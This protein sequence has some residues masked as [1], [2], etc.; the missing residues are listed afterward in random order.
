MKTCT[1]HIIIFY[2]FIINM[3]LLIY[4]NGVRN[5]HEIKMMPVGP[6]INTGNLSETIIIIIMMCSMQQ[7]QPHS[8][9][10][11]VPQPSWYGARVLP[12]GW[13]NLELTHFATSRRSV[14]PTCTAMGLIPLHPFFPRE[15]EW[16][17]R[18]NA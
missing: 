2:S 12:K 9:C 17:Q 1:H 3:L 7:L 10:S 14:F 15:S 11:G 5:M 13:A 16:L 8:P 4:M 6:L 18:I